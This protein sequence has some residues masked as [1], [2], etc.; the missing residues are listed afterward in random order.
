M[1]VSGLCSISFRDKSV[2][3]IISLAV[4]AGLEAVEW[5]GDVHVP[6]G[7]VELAR[8]VRKKTLEAGLKINSY[9]SYYNTGGEGNPP[10]EDVAA[11]ARALGAETIRIWAGPCDREKADEALVRKVLEDIS[12]CADRA[13][14]EGM[15]LSYEYHMNT[16]TN[17][18]ANAQLLGKEIDRES[19]RFYWQPPHHNS[20]GENLKGISALIDRVTNVHVFHW[21]LKQDGSIDRRMLEEGRNRWISFLRPFLGRKGDTYAFLEFCRHDDRENFLKD[22]AVFREI[23]SSL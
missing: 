8:E 19:V 17:T 23:L 6:H 12:R 9:G 16:F 20:D 15:T 22:A 2:D 7:E 10:F 14:A 18:D 1:I 11:T 3:E 4:E 5:G 21:L 13:E